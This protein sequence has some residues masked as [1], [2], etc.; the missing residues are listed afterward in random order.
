MAEQASA[1]DENALAPTTDEIRKDALAGPRTVSQALTRY[2]SNLDALREFVRFVAPVLH[3]RTR[4]HLQASHGPLAPLWLGARLAF[5]EEITSEEMA[6]ARETFGAEFSFDKRIDADGRTGT[7][8]VIPS[9]AA[10]QE[11]SE[12][13]LALGRYENQRKLLYQD[14]LINIL[15]ATEWF[16]ADLLQVCFAKYPEAAGIEGKSLTFEELRRLGSLDEARKYL[17]DAKIESILR[18]SIESWI[19]GFK[20]IAN[21]QDT[22]KLSDSEMHRLVEASQRRNLIVHNAG[23]VNSVYMS[24]V[25]E[26]LRRKLTIGREYI[27]GRKYLFQT[28]NLFEQAFVLLGAAY[29]KKHERGDT[30]RSDFMLKLA[31]K[32]I[33]AGR[34]QLAEALSNFSRFDAKDL[35]EAALL[36]G[37][38]N[39]W[40]SL[41]WQGRYDEIKSE[42]ESADYSA[43]DDIFCI[44]RFALLDD[45]VAALKLVHRALDSGKVDEGALNWPIFQ[46]LRKQDEMKQLCSERG[47]ALKEEDESQ[48]DESDDDVPGLFS[49][50]S[51]TTTSSNAETNRSN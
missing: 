45:F 15:S 46:E 11:M 26:S 25:H 36:S 1:S 47:I 20:R 21:I 22:A 4:K 50:N 42:I 5:G 41:K 39:Y 34:Y 49:V 51:P 38:L 37:Q 12:A 24:N 18:G 7:H 19:D 31:V 44:A 30:R 29:W 10:S 3:E 43:K 8:F 35:P 48:E 9:A 33:E 28:L 13:M 17:V 14:A 2:T 23:I 40:Q 6:R 32:H 16:G 27:V